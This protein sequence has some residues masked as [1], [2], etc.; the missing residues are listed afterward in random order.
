MIE[1]VKRVPTTTTQNGSDNVAPRRT[2][3]GR[4]CDAVIR[5]LERRTRRK[6]RASTAFLRIYSFPKLEEKRGSAGLR[7]LLEFL[8]DRVSYS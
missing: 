4:V 2:D 7:L 3:E 6:R 5:I 8:A 1:T